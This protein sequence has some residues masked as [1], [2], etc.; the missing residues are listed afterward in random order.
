LF[1]FGVGGG[2]SLSCCQGHFQ[3]NFYLDI[4][5]PSILF[6]TKS[7][8]VVPYLRALIFVRTLYFTKR[9]LTGKMKAVFI[10]AIVMLLQFLMHSSSTVESQFV[11]EGK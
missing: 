3:Q 4:S 7:M 5:L 8:Y 6:T 10:D 9:Q 1:C 2:Y 11:H